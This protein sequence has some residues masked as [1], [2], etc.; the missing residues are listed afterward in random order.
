MTTKECTPPRWSEAL[1]RM[2]LRPSDRDAISGD[3]LEEYR[4]VRRPA[5]GAV[6]ANA[7]Y[8]TQTASVLWRLMWPAAALLVA[9][10]VF[11]ALTVFQPG[12]HAPHSILDAPPVWLAVS[13]RFV[14]YGSL[15][16]APGVSLFDAAIYF[17]AAYAA[18]QR[19]RLIKTAVLI[20]ALTSIV[21]F[22]TLFATAAVVT[23]SLAVG[24]LEHP[25]LL[26]ILSTYFVIPLAYAAAIGALAGSLGSW[27]RRDMIDASG[28]SAAW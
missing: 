3:L 26:L 16:G 25:V 22:A 9:Q 23:P 20:S 2:M 19:T 17:V 15:V 14:W 7:W 1:L 4:A 13:F 21:G 10:S 5:L 11:L 8:L 28:R 6:G 12:H 27:L 24:L 18:V